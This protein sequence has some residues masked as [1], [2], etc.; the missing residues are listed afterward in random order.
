MPKENKSLTKA[1]EELMRHLWSLE[2]AFLKDLVEAY[3]EPRPAY[4]TVATVV[5]V[6]VKKG[7]IK[8]TSHGKVHEYSP[9]VSKQAYF[10]KHLGGLVGT[11]FEGSMTR[12]ASFFARQ[13]DLNVSQLEEI[14][15][16]IEAEIAERKGEEHG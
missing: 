6:L 14:K 3:P 13:D 1:E 5:R 9:A 16:L 11:F 2:K 10:K 12:F 7:F 8:Y 15:A 4:T